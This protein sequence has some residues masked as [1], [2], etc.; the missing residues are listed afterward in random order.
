MCQD[1][2][3]GMR[4]KQIYI[5]IYIYTRVDPSLYSDVQCGSKRDV[6]P[7]SM[8]GPKYLPK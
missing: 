4:H 3:Q 1:M 6:D 7:A 2:R 5:Y 8:F